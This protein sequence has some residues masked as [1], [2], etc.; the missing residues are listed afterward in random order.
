MK[1]IKKK[2]YDRLCRQPHRIA[3]ATGAFVL[4]SWI[5][6]VLPTPTLTDLAPQR[7]T[8]AWRRASM[9]LHALRSFICD[10][11]SRV[12]VMLSRNTHFSEHNITDSNHDLAVYLVAT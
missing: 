4:S 7:T 3:D 5:S 2:K 9:R 10:D 12:F 1:P 8:R 11:L 6:A